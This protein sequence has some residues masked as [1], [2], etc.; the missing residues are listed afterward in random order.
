MLFTPIATDIV[1]G[2]ADKAEKAQKPETPPA[3]QNSSKSPENSFPDPNL[4][5]TSAAAVGQPLPALPARPSSLGSGKSRPRSKTGNWKR[6]GRGAL[7]KALSA[8]E[9]AFYSGQT[10]EED[11]EGHKERRE[12]D[13]REAQQIGK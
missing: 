13:A 9:V 1:V 11:R 6:I 7:V 4:P 12:S 8:E 10:K 5:S 2:S 3:K